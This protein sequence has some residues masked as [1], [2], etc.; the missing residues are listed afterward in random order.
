L[1]VGTY[2]ADRHGKRWR[3]PQVSLLPAKQLVA[4]VLFRVAP[5]FALRGYGGQ[6]VAELAL[7]CVAPAFALRGY[8]GHAV[9]E[10]VSFGV[11]SGYN[12]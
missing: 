1:P 2:V 6:A 11:A 5:A 7:F 10:F 9:A 4:T 8:G 3:L 12:R